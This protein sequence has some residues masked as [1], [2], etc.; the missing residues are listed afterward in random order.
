MCSCV[1][2]VENREKAEIKQ[3]FR[4]FLYVLKLLNGVALVNYNEPENCLA[5]NLHSMT[6]FGILHP[7]TP[8]LSPKTNSA[9]AVSS[10]LTKR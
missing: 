5:Q 6:C 1:E 3:S 10:L 2:D 8:P 7:K 4:F 9:E